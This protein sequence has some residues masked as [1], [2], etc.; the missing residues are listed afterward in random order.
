MRLV[1]RDVKG[2]GYHT[3]KVTMGSGTNE[4]KISSGGRIQDRAYVLGIIRYSAEM[5][6]ARCDVGCFVRYPWVFS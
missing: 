3:P 1:W 4:M 6:G 5:A 2:C